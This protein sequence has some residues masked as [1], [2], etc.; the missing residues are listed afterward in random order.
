MGEVR[1]CCRD[2]ERRLR[3]MLLASVKSVLSR[4]STSAQLFDST[5]GRTSRAPA[6]DAPDVE[7]ERLG[8]LLQDRQARF[9]LSLGR[10]IANSAHP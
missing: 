10:T 3:F 7:S 8:E 9:T 6:E 5:G 1:Y 4:G 2:T